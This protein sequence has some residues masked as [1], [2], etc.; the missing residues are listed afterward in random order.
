MQAVMQP[1]GARVRAGRRQ[2]HRRRHA[3]A[4]R[5]RPRRGRSLSRPRR[6]GKARGGA[7]TLARC[8]TSA[9]CAPATA[10]PKCCAASIS[11][12]VAG[13]I[14]AVLGSNGVGKSTLNRDDLRDPARARRIDP[15]RRRGYRAREAG[16]DRRARPDPGAGRPPHL[17]RIFRCARTSISAVIVAPRERRGAEPRARVRD[18]PAPKERHRRS[19]ARCPA[20]SSRC[21]RSAAA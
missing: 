16:G 8:L 21:S 7:W 9:A 17:S 18:L 2:H 3:G 13:E 1:G 19:P 6:G 5:R 12:S 10:R 11:A 20:A 4:G 15:F 14:V